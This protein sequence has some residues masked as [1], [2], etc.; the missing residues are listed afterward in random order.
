MIFRRLGSV[1]TLIASAGV[2]AAQAPAPA[3]WSPPARP[4]AAPPILVN[5]CPAP[6]DL[7]ARQA[8]KAADVKPVSATADPAPNTPAPQTTAAPQASAAAPCAC[9]TGAVDGPG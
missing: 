6:A 4:P 5:G 8:A 1:A 2:A 3:N 9:A 7:V